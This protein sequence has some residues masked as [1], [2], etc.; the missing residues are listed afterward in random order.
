MKTAIFFG[1]SGYIGERTW[2]RLLGWFDRIVLSDTRNPAAKLPEG[3]EF[4]RCDVREPVIEQLAGAMDAAVPS[5]GSW[6]FHFSAVHRE[7]GHAFQEYFDTNIPGAEHV[8]AFAEDVGIQNIF[9]TSSI[10][11]YGETQ[12]ATDETA[13]LYPSSGY[14]ISKLAAELIHERWAVADPSRRLVTC[15]PGVVYGPGDPGNI[16]RMIRAVKQGIFFFPGNSQI[17]KSYAYIEGLLDSMEFT[18]ARTERIIRYN[19]VEH[20]TEPLSEL[21]EHAERVLGKRSR[22]IPLPLWLLIPA[23]Y[24]VQVLTRGNSAIHPKRV[25]KAA[26]STHIVPQWL[27]DHGFEFKFDFEKSLK[28]WQLKG[29][30]DF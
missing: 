25:R 20:P 21:V 5:A 2:K 16:L 24:L 12:G 23:A 1:G 11:V 8:T 22:T 29:P 9:F 7:P 4:V 28:D 19:Y 15:R 26:M 17:F 13:P 6:I 30:R 3:M 18:M 14:G 27:I 10:A